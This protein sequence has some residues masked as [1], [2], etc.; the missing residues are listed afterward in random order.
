MTRSCI[1]DDHILIVTIVIKDCFKAFPGILNVI[2]VPPKVAMLNNR[3]EVRLCK[4]KFI[5][6]SSS[7]KAKQ[8]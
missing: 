3:R 6:R 1:G 5:K 4:R 7:T 8:H 2:I